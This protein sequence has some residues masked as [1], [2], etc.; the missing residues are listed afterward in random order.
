MQVYPQDLGIRAVAVNSYLEAIGVLATI[1]AGITPQALHPS[2]FPI[3][4]LP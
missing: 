2:I 3:Q 1:K 4:P